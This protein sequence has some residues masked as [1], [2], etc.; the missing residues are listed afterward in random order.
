MSASASTAELEL[1]IFALEGQR[2]GLPLHAVERIVPAAEIT[3][4]PKAPA[5]VLGVIDVEGTILPVLSMRRRFGFA[6]R[7]IRIT[8]QFLIAHTPRR[9]VVL[10]IDEAQGVRKIAAARVTRAEKV[11][12]GFEHVRGVAALED[13]LVLIHDLEKFLSLD[14]A[15]ALEEAMAA[16]EGGPHGR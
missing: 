5:V 14:E 6:E 7:E 8:D 12:P 16:N 2:C 11:V 13:G 1:L 4:L 9:P 3:P 15:V 10:V